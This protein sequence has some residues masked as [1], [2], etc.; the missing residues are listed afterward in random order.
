MSNT[1][2][3]KENSKWKNGLI[4]EVSRQV[5]DGWNR[6]NGDRGKWR[7]L[8]KV[9]IDKILEIEMNNDLENK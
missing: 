5:E 3:H 6:I 1:F 9:K 4:T 7:K 8:R 2:R